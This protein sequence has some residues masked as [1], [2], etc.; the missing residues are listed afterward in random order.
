[1]KYQEKKY[2][3]DSFTKI[4]TILDEVGAKKGH[5]VITDHYYAQQ[6][7]ND[8]VK[9]VKYTD[10]NE[11]HI[12]GYS[13]GKYSLKE[14]IPVENTETG[15]QWLKN[16][17]YKIVNLVKMAYT[18]YEYKNGIVG[19][20]IIDDFLHSVILDF[21]EG[22]HR[23]IEKEFELNTTEVISVPYNKYL[24]QIGKLRSM[25]LN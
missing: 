12:L 2:Q 1:M 21:P 6:D 15:L 5:K 13:D 14:N 23:A 19:L 25:K 4:Q 16:K 18:D 11:I 22:H 20:Y 17:G 9:L 7:G 8:V 24:D 10:R 3:I